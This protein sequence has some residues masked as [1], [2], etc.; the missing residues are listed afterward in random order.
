ML[1]RMSGGDGG[2]SL[3][4]LTSESDQVAMDVCL[5]VKCCPVATRSSFGKSVQNIITSGSMV[6]QYLFVWNVCRTIIMGFDQ[7]SL[8]CTGDNGIDCLQT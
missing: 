3:A 6:N 2:Q 7:S 5:R 8:D 1:G 4:G